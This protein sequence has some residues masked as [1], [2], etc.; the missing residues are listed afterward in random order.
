MAHVEFFIW[1]G[2]GGLANFRST[3]INKINK[4]EKRGQRILDPTS[5]FGEGGSL[6]IVVQ[7]FLKKSV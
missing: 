6:T 3:L 1:E 4:M 2:G 7:P 5:F